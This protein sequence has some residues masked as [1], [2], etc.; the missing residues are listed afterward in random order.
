M[1]TDETLWQKTFLLWRYP[2]FLKID[3]ILP[4]TLNNKHKF[5]P[6]TSKLLFLLYWNIAYQN[7]WFIRNKMI[8]HLKLYEPANKSY[9]LFS[10]G[11]HKHIK[12][13]LEPWGHPV[14]NGYLKTS[15]LVLRTCNK[16]QTICYALANWF[17]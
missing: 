10:N 8:I 12:S 1:K 17:M 7:H 9:S 2:S 15:A 3:A 11:M 13:L 6:V 14:R 4:L 16:N 5:K